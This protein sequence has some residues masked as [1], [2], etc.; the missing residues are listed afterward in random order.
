MTCAAMASHTPVTA[1]M[2]MTILMFHEFNDMICE[3]QNARAA[4][5]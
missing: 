4:Q 1:Y 3:I 2:D 5:K